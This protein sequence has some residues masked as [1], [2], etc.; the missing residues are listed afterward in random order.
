MPRRRSRRGN[1]RNCTSGWSRKSRRNRQWSCH[2]SGDSL[3]DEPEGRGS[4]DE[5]LGAG[6]AAA[7][8]GTAHP[9]GR[10]RVGGT[11]NGV[12]TAPETVSPMNQKAE[13]LMMNAP[14]P[15]TPRQLKELHI[16]VVEE[17]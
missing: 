10:G 13:D 12:A 9:G 16:R 15:V 14:A 6:H 17:E 11:D 7:T 4:D 1:S 3:P 5:C 8:Q 2:C